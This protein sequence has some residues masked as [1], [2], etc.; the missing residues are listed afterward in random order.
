MTALTFAAIAA[1]SVSVSL[2][3]T[4]ILARRDAAEA[5]RADPFRGRS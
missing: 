3:L 1:V 2:A 4:I 5:R